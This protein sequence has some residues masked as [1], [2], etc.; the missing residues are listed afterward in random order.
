MSGK[1]L[2]GFLCAS[3]RLREGIINAKQAII[4]CNVFT[5]LMESFKQLEVGNTLIWSWLAGS[6]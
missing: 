2:G 5:K 4:E 1:W 3:F 6:I